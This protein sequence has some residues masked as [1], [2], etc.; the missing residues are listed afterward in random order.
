MAPAERK[1]YARLCNAKYNLPRN[2]PEGYRAADCKD[3]IDEF[4]T[5]V[6]MASE[7]EN[8]IWEEFFRQWHEEGNQAAVDA[9]N[10]K[11]DNLWGKTIKASEEFDKQYPDVHELYTR[12][13]NPYKD[14]E[15]D[16]V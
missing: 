7:D 8:R 12:N 16:S 15:N 11:L 6:G 4:R 3:R 10:K 9:F 2:S 5:I 13:D 14:N 1:F